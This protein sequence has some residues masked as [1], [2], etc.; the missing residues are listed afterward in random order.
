[1]TPTLTYSEQSIETSYEK[2]KKKHK[3]AYCRSP[4]CFKKSE[5]SD[6]RRNETKMRQNWRVF[7]NSKEKNTFSYSLHIVAVSHLKSIVFICNNFGN[8]PVISDTV[9]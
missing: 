1:M 3:C 9:S 7:S 8:S 4:L 2:K 6:L 5:H